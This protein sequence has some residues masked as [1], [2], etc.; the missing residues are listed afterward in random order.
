MTGPSFWFVLLTG[1][2]I[3]L[4]A[5]RWRG[6]VCAVL[7]AVDW[8]LGRLVAA[9]TWLTTD[10]EPPRPVVARSAVRALRDG[11]A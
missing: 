3:G 10:P 11:D 5:P 1:V 4:A 8:V 9:V 6:A 2:A 7:V